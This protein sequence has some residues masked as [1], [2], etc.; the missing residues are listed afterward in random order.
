MLDKIVYS[1]IVQSPQFCLDTQKYFVEAS[2]FI[3]TG[4]SLS[5][6]EC[7]LNSMPISYVFKKFYSGGGLG[8]KGY[9]Y[10]KAFINDL[11][12]PTI[13]DENQNIID[14]ILEVRQEINRLKAYQLS[15]PQKYIDSLV[16]NLLCLSNFEI[17][18]I[19]K[20]ML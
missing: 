4:D 20:N 16:C 12:I 6:L 9:R 8:K 18:M 14:E 2:A 17:E 5:Y 13:S 19:K 3:L 10:K 7:L 1:E 15:E 11:P